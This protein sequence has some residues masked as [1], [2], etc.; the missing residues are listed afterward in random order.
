MPEASGF[1]AGGPP[2][3]PSRGPEAPFDASNCF[4]G[5]LGPS[6]GGPA[7]FSRGG[8]GPGGPPRGPPPPVCDWTHDRHR[9]RA[10]DT[11]KRPRLKAYAC[12]TQ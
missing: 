6:R 12:K 5:G 9:T 4:G 1:A 11:G 10:M 8:G 7:A 2:A 3:G